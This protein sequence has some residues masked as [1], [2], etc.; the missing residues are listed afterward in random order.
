MAYT[1]ADFITHAE[2]GD[3][4]EIT[5]SAS[6]SDVTLD[7]GG[8]N[9]ILSERYK[10]KVVDGSNNINPVSFTTEDLAKL[11]LGTRFTARQVLESYSLRQAISDGTVTADSGTVELSSDP[12]V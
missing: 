9:I 8:Y 7:I 11:D 6:N 12:T 2:A 3:P 1:M 10:T 4:I 5:K